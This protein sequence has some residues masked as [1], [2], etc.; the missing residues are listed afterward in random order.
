M[1][2]LT[3]VEVKSEVQRLRDAYFEGTITKR[4]F[5]ELT[6]DLWDID[7]VKKLVATVEQKAMFAE[8]VSIIHS[9]I[10]H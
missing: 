9:V 1:T 7:R 2:E 8:I 3:L 5:E 10:S 4:E 6:E